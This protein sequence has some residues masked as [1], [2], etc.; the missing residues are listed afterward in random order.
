MKLK[1]GQLC[2][3]LVSGKMDDVSFQVTSGHRPIKTLS[4]T[5]TPNKK[6][7]NDQTFENW[8]TFVFL[9]LTKPNHVES[10]VIS[11]NLILN[12]PLVMDHRCSIEN[13]NT[14]SCKDFSKSYSLFVDID[15]TQEEN[16]LCPFLPKFLVGLSVSRTIYN[17][18]TANTLT[19]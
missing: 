13:T 16:H 15:L 11:S 7:R 4:A 17:R 3:F 9:P 8:Q 14:K 5:C 2:M 1:L 18:F 6:T 19:S 10:I 12:Y